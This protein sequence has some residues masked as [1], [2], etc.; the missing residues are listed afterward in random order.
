M[1]SVPSPTSRTASASWSHGLPRIQPINPT[2]N[3]ILDGELVCLDDDGRSVFLDLMRRKRRDV[4]FYA[5]DLLWLDG[6]DLRGLTFLER[7]IL[8]RKLVRGRAGFL[9]AEHVPTTGKELYQVICRE[10]LE[11]IVAKHKLAPYV[12]SPP[13]WFKVLNPAYTQKRGRRDLFD[14]FRGRGAAAPSLTPEPLLG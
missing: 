2:R 13:T 3:A 12:T 5:F 4:C 1:V 7:K 11:G 9:Y 14:N 6:K 8:L 10:D